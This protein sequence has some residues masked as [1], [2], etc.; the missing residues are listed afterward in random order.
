MLK[1]KKTRE[2]NSHVSEISRNFLED[3]FVVGE[4]RETELD[5]KL[6]KTINNLIYEIEFSKYGEH[7]IVHK[8][9]NSLQL[10]LDAGLNKE[11]IQLIEKYSNSTQNND[12]AYVLCLYYL[13]T[14]N[15]KMLEGTLDDAERQ[16]AET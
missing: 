15:Y 4:E 6:L 16:L 12:E 3:E 13:G 7:A 2:N 5:K 9:A 8:V 1:S 10:Y 11:L 14:Q